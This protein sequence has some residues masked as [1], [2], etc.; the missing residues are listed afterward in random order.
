[1]NNSQELQVVSA[2]VFFNKKVLLLQRD[3]A[4]GIKDPERWQLPGGG[5]ENSETLDVA[6]S[7]ELQEEIGIIPKM[8]YFL[9]TPYPKTHV[10]YAPL[11]KEEVKKIKKGNEG[12]DLRFFSL[13]E[14][15]NI[16]L[17]Q[18]LQQA[19][20]FQKNIFLSLLQ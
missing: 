5:V 12:K 15:L 20:E 6:I 16:P 2:I 3:D 4:F 11:T 7:R 10:Y 8:L 17:T 1:M 9:G 19:L 14:M 13:D 18:K